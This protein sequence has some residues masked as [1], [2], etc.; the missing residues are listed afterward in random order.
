MVVLLLTIIIVA[1]VLAL[2]DIPAARSCELTAESRHGVQAREGA[3]VRIVLTNHSVLPVV[4]KRLVVEAEN[5][6]TGEKQK[7]AIR[8]NALPHSTSEA[9]IGLAIGHCGKISFRVRTGR[10]TC[11]EAFCNF[12]VLPELF[13][14]R[15]E[16]NLHESDIYDSE[17]YSPYRKGQDFSEIYQI[18]EYV[19][20]DDIKHI[21]WKLS[22]KTDVTMVKE[23][24][25]PLDHSMMVVMDKSMPEGEC[26]PEQA[27]TLAEITVSI[28]RYLS[29]EKLEYQLIWND[30]AA[31][32]LEVRNVQFEEELA[33]AIPQML[34]GRVI[35]SDRDCARLYL[36]TVG[37]CNATHVIYI[38]CGLEAAANRLFEGPRITDLDARV[39]NAAQ[40]YRE[41]NLF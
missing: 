31:D 20:G 37:P 8:M 25:F 7:K 17:T 24:S 39:R 32:H 13:A 27:E 12:T 1:G 6:F 10:L 21:H 16:Y 9:E 29:D 11:K 19:P 38:S 3:A 34:T 41:I 30:P 35:R 23:A 26:T 2:L 14:T 5:T 28:C 4:Y 33:E 36:Q 18:R 22:E 15:I 40:E